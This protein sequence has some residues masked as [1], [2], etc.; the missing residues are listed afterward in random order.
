MGN[1]KL[2]EFYKEV[3]SES[4]S[5]RKDIN[6]VLDKII[7]FKNKNLTLKFDHSR[8]WSVFSVIFLALAAFSF[9]KFYYGNL[10]TEEADFVVFGSMV[11]SLVTVSFSSARVIA[12]GAVGLSNLTS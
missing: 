7:K 11:V 9:Y 1:Q 8:H 12:G 10:I 5:T 2:R 4:I 3:E 6:D